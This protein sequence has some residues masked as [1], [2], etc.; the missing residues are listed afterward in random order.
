MSLSDAE[1]WL[2]GLINVERLPQARSARFSLAP[3][4]ALLSALGDPQ[5]R[6]RVL[7]IAGSKGKGSVALFAEAILREAGLRTGV[8]TSPHLS[9]WTE[10]FRI[11]GVE[12]DGSRL[13]AAV[14]RIRPA[15][16]AARGGDEPPSF[17][18]AT[19]AA[20]LLLFESEDVDV[21]ILEV[22][23]GGRLDST[24]AVVP[25]VGVVTSIELEHTE[26]LGETLGAI[27]A[28]K[29]GIAKPGVPLVVGR[30]AEE[31]RLQ[32]E[33]TARAAGAPVA[34]LGRE[35]EF[36]A[37]G[38][39]LHPAF[40]L[41]DGALDVRVALGVPGAHQADN[42]ALATAAVHRLGLLEA[43]ALGRAAARALPSVVLPGRIEVVSQAPLVIIDSAH[44]AASARELAAALAGLER[45]SAH[46]VLSVSAGKGLEAIC[47]AIAPAVDR[48]TVTR[49]E[50]IRSLAPASVTA[51]LRRAAPRAEIAV[52]EDPREAVAA[53][54][55]DAAPEDLV[56]VTGSFYLAGVARD[57][58]IEGRSG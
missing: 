53:A 20:A 52:V 47:E 44:T 18:D 41:R 5:D 21:A 7:H 32:V 57:V 34:Q 11:D 28:E 33:A 36:G 49:A 9:R 19:T 13:A 39:A 29:A 37:T 3:I 38:D 58:W 27:A 23:L 4:R 25:A 51:S 2:E 16:E 54:R 22:G 50:P 35:L 55:R 40:A 10:R 31:A 6:L 8:F 15:V 43:A 45:A 56:F 26:I 14:E 46:L 1:A 48:V 24:N 17:F 12:V 42:A 30:L